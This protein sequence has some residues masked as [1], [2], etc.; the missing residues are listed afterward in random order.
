MHARR[1]VTLLTMY[2]AIEEDADLG[3]LVQ[4][5]VKHQVPAPEWI[6]DRQLLL[7]RRIRDLRHDHLA[8]R[9]S[10]LDN[11]IAAKQPAEQQISAWEEER[12]KLKETLTAE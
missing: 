2:E 8:H 4:G 10:Q 11:M 7:A 5:Y 9:L 12:A 6:G 1:D 3:A